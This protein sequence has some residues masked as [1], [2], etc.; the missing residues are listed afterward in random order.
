MI[1]LDYNNDAYRV[2][3]AEG[4][5]KNGNLRS[6]ARVGKTKNDYEESSACFSI[7]R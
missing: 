1:E 7:R 5:F 4:A 2:F 6:G 3:I